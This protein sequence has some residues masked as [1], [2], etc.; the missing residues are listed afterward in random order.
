MARPG[1]PRANLEQK[2]LAEMAEGEKRLEAEIRKLRNS[3]RSPRRMPFEAACVLW[4]LENGSEYQKACC[5]PIIRQLR[6]FAQLNGPHG[7]GNS[8]RDFLA[9]FIE[10]HAPAWKWREN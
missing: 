3:E 2:I 9:C 6:K 5:E 7:A 4:T 8:D 10:K 1:R